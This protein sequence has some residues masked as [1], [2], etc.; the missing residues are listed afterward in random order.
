M[1]DFI[2]FLRLDS[3]CG[4]LVAIAVLSLAALQ[5][6]NYYAVYSIQQSYAGEFLAV[7][8]DYLAS[9]CQALA[10]MNA[11]ERGDYLASLDRSRGALEKPFRFRAA[12]APDWE[13]ET[14]YYKS[15]LAREAVTKI[16]TE[17]G[18]PAARRARARALQGRARGIVAALRWLRLPDD[19]DV[20]AVRG[21]KLA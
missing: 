7:G 4:Q 21:R 2:K 10:H 16:L 14:D 13:T 5:C 6:V 17:A 9:V 18:V 8:H 12:E 19:A 11:A 20:R 1:K 15:V 3:L